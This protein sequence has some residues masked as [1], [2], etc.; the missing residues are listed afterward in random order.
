MPE[1]GTIIPCPFEMGIC[2]YAD[3]QGRR[4]RKSMG[5]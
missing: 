3:T 1:M 2:C 4:V 5:R